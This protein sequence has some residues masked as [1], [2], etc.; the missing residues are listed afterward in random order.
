MI[1]TIQLYTNISFNEKDKIEKRFKKSIVKVMEELSEDTEGI[2]ITGRGK[3]VDY[4]I[5]IHVD[6]TKILNKGD[7][8]EDDYY[9]VQQEIDRIIEYMIGY[10]LE[11]TLLRI[12]Y[13]VDICIESSSE[14][15]IL[16]HIYKKMIRKFGFKERRDRDEYKTSVMYNSGSI[17]LMIYDK[18][19]ERLAKEEIPKDYEKN[20]LRFEVKILNNHLNYNKH[21]HNISKILKN[22]F[23]EDMKNNYMIKNIQKILYKGNYY[24]IYRADKIIENSNLKDIDKKLVRNFLVDVSK[25]GITGAKSIKKDN[26]SLKYTSYKYKKIIKLLEELNINPILIPKNLKSPNGESYSYIKNPFNL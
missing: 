21:K 16:F 20:M 11:L 18:D 7:V 3:V 19:E 10:T 13:R 26:K 8:N 9:I 12:E 23:T 5:N 6:V 17:Q 15:Y 25:S 2:T 14:R 22:Y 24:N 4:Y 1:H